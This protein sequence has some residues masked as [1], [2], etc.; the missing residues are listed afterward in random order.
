MSDTS[1]AEAA[2]QHIAAVSKLA[3][4]TGELNAF[5]AGTATGGPAGNG[6][7][8]ITAPDGTVTLYL[9]PAK[10]ATM[11]QLSQADRDLLTLSDATARGALFEAERKSESHYGEAEPPHP[12]FG[13]LWI[14]GDDIPVQFWDGE[15]W[16]ASGGG[17]GGGGRSAS[18]ARSASS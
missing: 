9:C 13:D 16:R 12:H 5:F 4:L 18:G 1:W 10:I 17:G 6:G 8:P 2:Q 7:Y 15:Q 11:T 3:T 14:N